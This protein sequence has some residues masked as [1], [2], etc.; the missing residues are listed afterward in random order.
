MEGSKRVLIYKNILDLIEAIEDDLS[1]RVQK[2]D[3]DDYDRLLKEIITVK[4]LIRIL[5]I[6]KS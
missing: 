5:Q 6:A 1:R 4:T 2:S 3:N